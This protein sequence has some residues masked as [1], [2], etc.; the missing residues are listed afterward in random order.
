MQ[1]MTAL[2][3]FLLLLVGITLF[4][5]SGCA[6][7]NEFIAKLPL[8]EAKSDKIPGLEPPWKRKKLI[9]QKGL[10][11]K[12]VS[13]SEKEILVAQLMVEYRTSPDP[14]MRREAVDAMAKIPHPKRDGY[15]KEILA[16]SD[17]FVRLSALEALGKTYSGTKKELALLLIENSKKDTDKDVRLTAIRLLADSFPKPS[18]KTVTKTSDEIDSIILPALGEALYDKVPAVRYEAMQ[19]LHKVTGKDY[20]NDINRWILYIQY[21][22]GE[23][24]K[25]PEERSFAEKLPTIQLPMFK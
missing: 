14:N 4:V 1:I 7:D 2:K 17:P 10:Q 19:S 5:T 9:Q 16:D 3:Y 25:P 18:Q 22:K 21:Q 12:T 8:F 23:T 13:D 24:A 15:M 11:G 20:G 6:V